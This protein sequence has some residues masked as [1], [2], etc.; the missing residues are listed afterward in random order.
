MSERKY[1]V[2]EIAEWLRMQ[3]N[4]GMAAV[5]GYQDSGIAAYF[6][7][8]QPADSIDWSHVPEGFDFVVMNAAGSAWAADGEMV[9]ENGHWRDAECVPVPACDDYLPR[10]QWRESLRR[11]P[12]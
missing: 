10:A 8:K 11:R 9:P 5:V 2:A 3:S 4:P 1:S 12:A 6:A 7:A